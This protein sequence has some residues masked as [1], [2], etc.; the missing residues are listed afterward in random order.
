MSV[1]VLVRHAQASFHADDYDRLSPLGETQARR[2]GE[3]WARRGD[4]FDE[5]YCGPRRRQQQTAEQVGQGYCKAGLSWPEP[6]VLEELDEY[7]LTGLL[8]RLA[9]ALARRDGAFDELVGDHHRSESEPQRSRSFQRMFERLLEHWQAA[10]EETGAVEAW[11]AFRDRVARGIRRITDGPGR[12][13]RVVAFTSGGV[14]GAAVALALA[15]PDRTALELSW[16][17]RNAALTRLLF[18]PGRLTLDEFNT[19]PHLHDPALWT[20]R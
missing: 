13:R 8:D 19:V 15:A 17:I 10:A 18:S 5:V 2:L 7:D 14:I 16:R 6:I 9:P 11:P 1:L 12:S 3:D 20:Y 4:L